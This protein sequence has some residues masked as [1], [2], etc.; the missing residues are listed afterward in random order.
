MEDDDDEMACAATLARVERDFRLE[1]L[2]VFYRLNG[3]YLRLNLWQLEWRA[4]PA[5]FCVSCQAWRFGHAYQ[6]G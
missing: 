6:R 1:I 2:G 5:T 3:R 4:L